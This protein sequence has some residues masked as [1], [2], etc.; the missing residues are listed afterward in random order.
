MREWIEWMK[1]EKKATHQTIWD[2]YESNVFINIHFE[3]E[4]STDTAISSV[5]SAAQNANS[6]EALSFYGSSQHC[7]KL[8][9]NKW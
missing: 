5:R 6:D 2:R 3:I 1:L 9:K 8:N 7:F 4:M